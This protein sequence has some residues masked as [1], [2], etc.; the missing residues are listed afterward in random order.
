MNESI[1]KFEDKMQ[2]PVMDWKR[3]LRPFVQVE[4]TRMY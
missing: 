2:K 3:N 4:Q 1:A